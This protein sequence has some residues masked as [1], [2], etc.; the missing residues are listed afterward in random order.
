MQTTTKSY[1]FRYYYHNIFLPLHFNDVKKKKGAGLF[2]KYFGNTLC[3]SPNLVSL[4]YEQQSSLAYFNDQ[5]LQL[6]WFDRRWQ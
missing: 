3:L 6:M 1:F 5:R 2:E 4:T